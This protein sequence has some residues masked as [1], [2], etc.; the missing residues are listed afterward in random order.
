MYDSTYDWFCSLSS[1]LWLT[2]GLNCDGRVVKDKKS[3]SVQCGTSIL[4][5][6]VSNK[7]EY[8]SFMS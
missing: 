8:K 3:L 7:F 1:I 4:I 2:W 5:Q 6:K